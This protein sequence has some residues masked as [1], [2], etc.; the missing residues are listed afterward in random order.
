M[1]IFTGTRCTT[2][3]KLPVAFSTGKAENFEPEPS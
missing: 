1:T 2:L 3:T